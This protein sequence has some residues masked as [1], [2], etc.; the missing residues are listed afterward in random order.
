MKNGTSS[1]TVI[2]A[3]FLANLVIALVKFI[4]A[5]ITRSSAMLAE[6]IEA[7]KTRGQRA[8]L[9][10]FRERLRRRNLDG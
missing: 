2:L 5:I 7:S 10:V 4:V 9:K 6:A 3:A 1:K 8:G